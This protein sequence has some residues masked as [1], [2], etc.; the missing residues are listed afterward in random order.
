M[1]FIQT[2]LT[3]FS[4]SIFFTRLPIDQPVEQYSE[5]IFQTKYYDHSV[6]FFQVFFTN[7]IVVNFELLDVAPILGD[8]KKDTTYTETALDFASNTIKQMIQNGNFVISLGG[9]EFSNVRKIDL[10]DHNHH[11]LQGELF[12]EKHLPLILAI[13][14]TI[15]V[16]FSPLHLTQCIFK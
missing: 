11:F 1:T 13:L 12:F 3:P 6:L 7:N 2:K 15:P 8:V 16:Y 10:Y 9:T 4:Q 14:C 5:N